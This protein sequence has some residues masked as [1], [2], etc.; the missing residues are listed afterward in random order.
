MIKS[1]VETTQDQADGVVTSFV[2]K[3]LTRAVAKIGKVSGDE[4]ASLGK[5][6]IAART[7]NSWINFLHR[8]D[9]DYQASRYR[10]FSFRGRHM[11]AQG[12]E[13]NTDVK[14]RK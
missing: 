6:V 8:G 4:N 10:V 1:G 11:I 2:R 13:V 5:M 14:R 12:K 7:A 3:K 9:D